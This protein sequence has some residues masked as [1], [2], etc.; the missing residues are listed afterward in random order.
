MGTCAASSSVPGEGPQFAMATLNRLQLGRHA[1]QAFAVAELPRH[2][3]EGVEGIGDYPLVVQSPGKHQRLFGVLAGAVEPQHVGRYTSAERLSALTC[4][5]VS[6]SR[7]A[8]ARAASSRGSARLASMLRSTWPSWMSV[9][10]SSRESRALRAAAE[11]LLEA[12]DRLVLPCLHGAAGGRARGLL[13]RR[14]RRHRPR[15]QG[16]AHWPAPH[17]SAPAQSAARRPEPL[18][19]PPRRGEYLRVRARRRPKSGG[20]ERRHA[21]RHRPRAAIRV[22]R[23]PGGAGARG[24]PRRCLRRRSRARARART[25]TYPASP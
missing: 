20:R 2:E 6:D 9:C 19:G 10:I 16:R 8:R 11:R 5:V 3:L 1:G 17:H 25:S 15:L 18:R 23:R 21:R 4:A 14:T 7:V 13:L 24:E 12:H 22:R